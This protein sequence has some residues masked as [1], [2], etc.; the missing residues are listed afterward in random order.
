MLNW[1]LI[2]NP[3]NWAVIILMVMIAMF[4]FH[5]ASKLVSG[6]K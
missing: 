6:A 1:P 5:F 4:A 3:I 2:K